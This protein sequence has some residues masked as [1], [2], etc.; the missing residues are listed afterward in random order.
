MADLSAPF[1]FLGAARDLIHRAKYQGNRPAALLLGSL[2]AAR[3][4]ID[5]GEVREALIVP[6]PLHPTRLRER[7]FNQAERLA[8]S[9]GECAGC[10]LR[11]NVL[12][13][14]RGSVSQTTLDVEE[15]RRSVAGAFRVRERLRNRAIILVDDV[16]TTGATAEACRSALLDAGARGPIRVLVGARTL[17]RTRAMT[18]VRTGPGAVRNPPAPDSMD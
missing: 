18:A 6:V 9:A 5:I 3:L 4:R 7:G 1:P 12:V 11:V 10:E 14:T 2:M 13:R 15:R 8:R 16:W 17:P